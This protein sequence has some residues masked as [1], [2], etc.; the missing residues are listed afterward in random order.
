MTLAVKVALNPNATNQQTEY[1]LKTSW[2]K[3][4]KMQITV[5]FFFSYLLFLPIQ[6]QSATIWKTLHHILPFTY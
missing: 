3:K 2:E 5:F 1:L 4:W 6:G